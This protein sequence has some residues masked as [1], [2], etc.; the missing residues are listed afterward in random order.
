MKIVTAKLR[1][2]KINEFGFLYCKFK[3]N[4]PFII[5]EIL[6]LVDSKFKDFD[7]STCRP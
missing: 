1:R 2:N 5:L 6:A 7:L 4:A 3:I